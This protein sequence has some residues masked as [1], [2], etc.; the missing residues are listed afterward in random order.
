MFPQKI[1]ILPL[2]AVLVFFFAVS[3]RAEKTNDPAQ[4][5]R[6]ELSDY[7]CESSCA[8][9]PDG[10]IYQGTFYGWF[11]ALTPEGKVKWKCKSGREIKSSPAVAADGTIYFGS[12]DRKFYALTPAGKLKWS[13]PTGAWVDSSPAIATDGTVYF[14]SWDKSF[15]AL[16]PDGK[17]KWKFATSNLVT[18]S[19]AIAADGTIYFGS[20]DKNFYALTPDGKLKWKFPTGAEI[21]GSPAI[22]ADGT[23]YFGSTDGKLYALRPDGSEL[24]HLH[25]GS[26]TAGSPVLDEEGN[27]YLAANKEQIAVSR[28]GKLIWRHPTEVPLDMAWAVAAN[29]MVYVSMPWLSVSAMDRKNPWPPAWYFYMTYNLNSSPNVNPQGIIYASDSTTLFAFKPVNAAPLVKSSWPMWR[30]NPQHTGRVQQGN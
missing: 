22:A 24:W 1:K 26:Y 20:H 3:L 2:L 13:F 21:D 4:L 9:A 27:L 5:W 28:E 23:I 14:G 6:V 12:R 17:L 11:I 16:A 7:G 15:Y 30:A 25:T 10:T 29:G 8:L 18:T 19:P